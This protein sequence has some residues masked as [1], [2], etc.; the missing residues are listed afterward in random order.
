MNNKTIVKLALTTMAVTVP[1]VG[2]TGLVAAGG[3]KAASM[4]AAQAKKAQVSAAKA[5]KFMA[6]GEFS[7]ALP[8]AEAAVAGDMH[9]TQY[10]VMLSRVYMAEGRF[11]SAERTL[12]DVM[13][14]GQVDPRSVISLSLVRTAQGKTDS[15]ISLVEAHRAILP[16][17]DYALALALAGDQK[18]AIDILVDA[19]RSDN[20]NARTRQNLALAYALDNRWREAQVMAKQDMNAIAADKA[21][22]EWAQYARP[23]AYETRVAGL[24]K[25]TPN[26]DDAGQP[27]RLALNGVSAEPVQVASADSVAPVTAI[28]AVDTNVELS[29]VEPAAEFTVAMPTEAPAAAPADAP[30]QMAAASGEIQFVSNP[31]MAQIIRG[32]RDTPLIKAE[33]GPIKGAAK[34]AVASTNE[35]PKIVAQAKTRKLA[36]ADT[37]APASAKSVGGSHLVQL[38]A[39]TTSASAQRAW[40]S[41]SAKHGVLKGTKSASST[42]T[43]NGKQLV[44][45]AASG[46]DSYGSANAACQQIKARGDSCIVR[47]IGGET[48]VR[49]AAYSKKR[50]IASR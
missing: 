10:R 37:A 17:S 26:R 35:L 4:A 46:F 33:D 50:R 27:V 7:K 1:T 30:V 39:F 49:M 2:S 13:D 34:L 43:V 21:I 9:N 29:A 15:A 38:G 12:M 18:R 44:R 25:V 16:A 23:G 31:V 32:P 19:I 47:S 22:V 11:R 48:P 5:E 6:K 41:L 3:D 14:L 24:L 36:L 42:V 45:L 8:F 28:A 40:G 20:A